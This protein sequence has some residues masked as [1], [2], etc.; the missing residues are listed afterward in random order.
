MFDTARQ[1]VIR[2][3]GHKNPDTDSICSAVAYAWLKN[4]TDEGTYEP[5]RAGDISRE[6]AFVLNH[7]GVDVPRLSVDMRP[8]ISNIDIRQE[9]GVDGGMSMRKAWQRM[10]ERHIDTLVITDEDNNL[11]GLISVKDIA[12]ANMEIFNT[13]VLGDARTSYSNILEVLDGKMLIGD[14]DGFVTGGNLHVG[15]SPEAMAELVKPGDVVMVSNR[16]EAQMCAIDYGAQCIVVCMDAAVPDILL[17]RAKDS[18]CTVI[19]THYDTYA[20]SRLITMAAPIGHF[21]VSKDLVTFHLN[22]P[23]EE[24]RRV[25]ASL[26]HR[27]FPILDEEGKYCGVV[28]R[29]NLLNMHRKKVIIVDHNEMSQAVD[30][31]SEAEVLEI[32]DH[33]RIG[34]METS[35]PVYFRNEPVGCTSTII[36][37]MFREK[38]VEIPKKI[39]GLMLS[40]ILSDTMMFHSPT[41][42]MFDK[43]AAQDLASIAGEDINEYGTKMFEAGEDLTG[44]TAEDVLYTDFK[45]FAIGKFTIAVGQGFYMSR[46]AYD[47]ATGLISGILE[48][49]LEHSGKDMLFYLVTSIPDQSSRLL[50]AGKYAGE[51][52]FEAFGKK[53]ENGMVIL[54]GVVSRKKQFI[55]P[56]RERLLARTE[57]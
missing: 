49:E 44:R 20:A 57:P 3:I 52:I 38:N 54:D 55:P 2:V 23:I 36:Y 45:E 25:M 30:G 12:N 22:T 1:R 51:V 9:P 4:H 39:A 16:Y 24:A 27:Y 26:R 14:P 42:T 43:A 40:A 31:L 47:C 46:K 8:N 19:T 10:N 15:T 11:E 21:C 13:S 28:S 18:G 5:R 35:G 29:R 41:C 7:F 17:K 32:I 50:Y 33:H 34:T 53:S 56:V 37:S 48:N 6:T